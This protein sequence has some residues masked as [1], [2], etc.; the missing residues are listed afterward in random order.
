MRKNS[1]WGKLHSLRGS[2]E[3][4]GWTR[5]M[6]TF[7]KAT[8]SYISMYIIF[9]PLYLIILICAELIYADAS[10]SDLVW[11]LCF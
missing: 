8:S 5:I 1:L 10:S 2:N 3:A 6:I 4:M 7:R 11:G 9:L